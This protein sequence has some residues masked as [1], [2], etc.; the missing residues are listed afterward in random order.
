MDEK[1]YLY[2]LGAGASKPDGVPTTSELIDKAFWNFGGKY[3]NQDVF[4]LGT[5][6]KEKEVNPIIRPVLKLY[7]NFYDT[8][9]T[10]KLDDYYKK[11]YH[12]LNLGVS[13]NRIEDFFS[14]LY[15]MNKGIDNYGLNLTKEEILDISRKAHYLFFHTLAY[16]TIGNQQPK[17]YSA[18]IEKFLKRKGKHCIISFNYDLLLE[19]ALIS[20]DYL[21]YIRN[22]WIYPDELKW[23]YG[24]NFAN[25]YNPVPYSFP[26]EEK[27]KILYY[28]L[29]GSLNW[30]FC[31]EDKKISLHTLNSDPWIYKSFYQEQLRC[32]DATHIC[33]PLLIPPIKNK[34]IEIP[35]LIELW[36][37]AKNF[38]S[39][40]ME[41]HII[42]YS[43]PEVDKEANNLLNEIATAGPAKIIIANPNAEHV[44]KFKNIFKDYTGKINLY[45]GF[46]EY[47]TS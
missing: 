21:K 33:L 32:H 40:E 37:K 11:G 39:R 45:S 5:W 2:I 8:D 3:E 7:D 27:A 22:E 46:E 41:L 24:I 47:L 4:L 26:I 28:K 43:L 16:S 29:H 25:S 1:I 44:K 13:T 30:S 17:Y 23:T 18:F 10:K 36:A 19:S 9:L 12:S 42:G 38:I 34:E 6:D 31:P 20:R 15:Y 14:R 35:E